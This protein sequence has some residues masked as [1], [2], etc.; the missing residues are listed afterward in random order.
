MLNVT[1]DMYL[2]YNMQ[3]YIM[4]DLDVINVMVKEMLVKEHGIVSNVNM[5]YVLIVLVKNRNLLKKE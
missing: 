4:V 2:K 5:I 1:K 3:V